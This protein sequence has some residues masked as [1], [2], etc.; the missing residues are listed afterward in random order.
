MI[1]WL[2]DE[3]F[4]NAILKAL[5]RRLPTIDVVRTQDVMPAGLSDQLLLDRAAVMSRLLLTHDVTTMTRWAYERIA[6]GLPT[7]GIFE[8]SNRAAIRDVLDDL[9]LVN[10]SSVMEEWA[11]QV[12]YIPFL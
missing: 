9:V 6:A 4:N 3:N 11:S 2:A 5:R 8:V 10:E 1:R 12:I 7:S